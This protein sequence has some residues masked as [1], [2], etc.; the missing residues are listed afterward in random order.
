MQNRRQLSLT[1]TPPKTALLKRQGGFCDSVIVSDSIPYKLSISLARENNL[2]Y[3]HKCH[4]VT[5]RRGCGE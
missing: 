1:V 2:Y 4:T 5:N 3:C